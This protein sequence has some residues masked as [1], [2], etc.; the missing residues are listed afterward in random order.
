M[1]FLLFGVPDDAIYDAVGAIPHRAVRCLVTQVR[2]LVVYKVR[3]SSLMSYVRWLDNASTV[4]S[5]LRIASASN[6]IWFAA[7]REN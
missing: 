5:A 3:P 2:M 7:R 1:R 4:I 6:H